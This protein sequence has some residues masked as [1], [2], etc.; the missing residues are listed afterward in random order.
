MGRGEG[1]FHQ[2]GLSLP[3]Y[4]FFLLAFHELVL[5]DQGLSEWAL[6]IPLPRNRQGD[7][8]LQAQARMYFI[9]IPQNLVDDK[10]NIPAQGTLLRFIA[11]LNFIDKSHPALLHLYSNRFPFDIS[12][13][14]FGNRFVIAGSDSVSGNSW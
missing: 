9:S 8:L 6:E 3:E 11:L 10:G 13:A 1:M 7:W 4:Y 2:G 5:R 12:V 14:S